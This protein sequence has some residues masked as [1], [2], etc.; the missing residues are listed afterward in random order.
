MRLERFRGAMAGD[1]ELE[2]PEGGQ[3]LWKQTGFQFEE[4]EPGGLYAIGT[5]ADWGYLVLDLFGHYRDGEWCEVEPFEGEGVSDPAVFLWDHE[6]GPMVLLWASLT[7]CLEAFETDGEVLEVPP[8]MS[9]VQ[10]PSGPARS[11]VEAFLAKQRK[12]T[13]AP[14]PVDR[15]TA[16]AWLAALGTPVEGSYR[17]KHQGRIFVALSN[18][19]DLPTVLEHVPTLLWFTSQGVELDAS[20]AGELDRGVRRVAAA[21]AQVLEASEE[22]LVTR[23]EGVGLVGPR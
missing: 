18:D 12:P 9:E 3:V 19:L 11:T 4:L 5:H 23:L 6:G 8:P 2:H 1:L 7:A 13:P 16:E 17:R 22:E 14:P 10:L 21:L 20:M 15:A